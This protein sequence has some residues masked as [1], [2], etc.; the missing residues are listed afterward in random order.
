MCTHV[1]YD[2]GGLRL[3]DP[4]LIGYTHIHTDAVQFQ[5]RGHCKVTVEGFWKQVDGGGWGGVLLNVASVAQQ[6]VPAGTEG[7]GPL[8][9]G[10]KYTVE[11]V[12]FHSST[13]SGHDPASASE[14][15]L[16]VTRHLTQ[17]T[18]C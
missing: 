8:G 17:I 2:S 13:E 16:P 1:Q 5:L 6:C 12:T 4:H 14:C 15:W 18:T 7:S 10:V 3:G 11:K 9:P